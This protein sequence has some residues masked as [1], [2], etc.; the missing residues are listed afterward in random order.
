[1]KYEK[2]NLQVDC[3]RMKNYDQ[4]VSRLM[5]LHSM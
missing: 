1:M 3:G 4:F 2:A 5:N